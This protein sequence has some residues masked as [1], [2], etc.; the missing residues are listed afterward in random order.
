MTQSGEYMEVQRKAQS[1]PTIENVA[2][3]AKDLF[4][5]MRLPPDYTYIIEYVCKDSDGNK[6][7]KSV[8]D[9][10]CDTAVVKAAKFDKDNDPVYAPTL[11]LCKSNEEDLDNSA[12]ELK[13][14]LIAAR[15]PNGMVRTPKRTRNYFIR[16]EDHINKEGE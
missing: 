12:G 10:S 13:E 8:P 14:L 11:F 16:L 7:Y 3:A 5:I 6:V 9:A 1:D 2:A 4:R 15:C